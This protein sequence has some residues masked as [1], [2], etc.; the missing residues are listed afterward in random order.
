[1][2]HEAAWHLCLSDEEC[3]LNLARVMDVIYKDDDGYTNSYVIKDYIATL[4]E[5]LVP[6]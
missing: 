5:K 1:M 6:F 4:L 2:L 3:I